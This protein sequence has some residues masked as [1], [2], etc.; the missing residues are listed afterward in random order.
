MLYCPGSPTQ[1]TNS[2]S[3]LSG[4]CFYFYY[5]LAL[6]SFSYHAKHWAVSDTWYFYSKEWKWAMY[7][8]L[9]CG[10][11]PLTCKIWSYLWVDG[12]RVEL[13]CRTHSWCLKISGMREPPLPYSHKPVGI[14]KCRILTL[15]PNASPIPALILAFVTIIAHL[16]VC[17]TDQT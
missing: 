17:V 7:L 14:I 12:I 6:E 1:R 15:S 13:N 8:C 10:T 2:V 3:V 16:L 4:S 5:F 11:E 9:S